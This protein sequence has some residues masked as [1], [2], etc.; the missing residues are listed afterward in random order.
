MSE[1]MMIFSNRLRRLTIVFSRMPLFSARIQ[2]LETKNGVKPER[3]LLDQARRAMQ[4][5]QQKAAVM[6]QTLTLKRQVAFVQI[7]LIIV[8]WFFFVKMI[9]FL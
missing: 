3:D 5:K 1:D 7:Q 2:Q 6:Y 9:I 8:Q 4:E